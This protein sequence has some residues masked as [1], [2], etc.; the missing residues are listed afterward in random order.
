VSSRAVNPPGVWAPKG[1]GF[2]MATVAPEGRLIHLTG[3]VAW[4]ADETIVGPGDVALQTEQC[5]RNIETVLAA[6]GGT[7]A[8]IVNLTTYYTAPDQLAEIQ[9]V[10]ARWLDATSPPAS[11]SVMVA[12][13]GHPD[14]LVELTPVAVVPVERFRASN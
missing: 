8:D 12:G 4:D 9:Q 5:F 3:Q 11:T 13:L 2:S 14:F 6:V 10:R 1:R 7:L